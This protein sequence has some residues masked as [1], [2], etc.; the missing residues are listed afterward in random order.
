MAVAVVVVVLAVMSLVLLGTI[1]PVRQE[2]GVALLRVQ[3]VRA[4][5]AA[6]SGVVVVIGGLGAGLELPDPGDSLS[7]SEQSVTFEA[8]PDGPGV[9]AVTGK[10]GG[11]RRRISLDIE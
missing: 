8:V 7:F 9:I 6:E 5:Y 11:A 1:R 2:T 4:F 10:S 3:T